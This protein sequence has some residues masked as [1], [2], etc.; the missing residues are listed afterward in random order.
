MD[1]V[2]RTEF[3]DA[4]EAMLYA[5]RILGQLRRDEREAQIKQQETK[6]RGT[7][8]ISFKSLTISRDEV[9]T[10]EIRRLLAHHGGLEEIPRARLQDDE[11]D[12][13]ERQP[14]HLVP[15]T[16]E[17]ENV[18]SWFK[19]TPGK[20]HIDD[21]YG[22]VD[23]ISHGIECEGAN[24]VGYGWVAF[25]FSR[26]KVDAWHNACIAGGWALRKNFP[27]DLQ[28]LMDSEFELKEVEGRL[29]FVHRDKPAAE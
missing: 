3:G 18:P 14:R 4:A 29:I 7:T 5:V 27:L 16:P 24:Y 8:N 23:L 22:A 17:S 26:A 1:E 9:L 19:S 28:E 6:P 11:R 10:D 21:F 12:G 13:R 20:Y 25:V 15:G 2:E